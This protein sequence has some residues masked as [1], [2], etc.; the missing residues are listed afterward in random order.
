M[1]VW[2]PLGAAL[3]SLAMGGSAAAEGVCSSYL[4]PDVGICGSAPQA[5][6]SSQSPP[7]EP[8][9][10]EVRIG[11][12]WYL[13]F[14]QGSVN[15]L[16]FSR[17]TI[18]RGYINIEAKL[19]RFMSARITPDVTQ[20]A[21][22]DLKVRLKYAYAKFT[23]RDLGF[24]KRPEVEFGV[25]HMPWLD[26]EEHLNNYRMQDTMFMERFGLFNSADMGV[27]FI[28]L[29]GGTLSEEYRKTVNSYFP[30]RYGSFALGVYNGGG[31]HAREENTNKAFEGRLSI[32]PIP[33]QAPGLQVS[34]FGV[35][36][37]GNTQN[38]PDWRVDAVMASY[39]SRLMVLTGTWLDALGNQSGLAVDAT[40]QALD[41]KGWSLFG[42]AKLTPR[43]SV[44]ARYDWY[45]PNEALEQNTLRRTIVGA[46]YHI[47]KGNT[48]LVDYDRLAYDQPGRPADP[49]FQVT[50]QVSY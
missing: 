47:G 21:A 10:P 19:F 39:E 7:S 25:A 38:A 49:R 44:I 31:Y 12:L 22:G 28:G 3:A 27:T 14:Q 35:R 9:Y 1:Q 24:I 8:R 11:G 29:I 30:G 5:A 45:D 17:F 23:P 48:V 13:S 20:E 32:R 15:D 34:Y 4:T 26:F 18:K 42:E 37:K 6:S 2:L 46:A 41:A 50:V 33:D 36:G 16:D 43:F 40:G